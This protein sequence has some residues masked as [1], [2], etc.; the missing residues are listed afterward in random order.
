LIHIAFVG[1]DVANES[2]RMNR[3]EFIGLAGCAALTLPRSARA[4]QAKPVIG[5]LHSGTGRRTPTGSRD[6]ARAWPTRALSK[7]RTSP[8]ISLGGRTSGPPARHEGGQA[9]RRSE[10]KQQSE[11]SQKEGP[12]AYAPLTDELSSEDEAR[13][14]REKQGGR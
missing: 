12:A 10:Q 1:Q 2:I 8:S 5:F 3:R 11:K 13:E 6:F 7:T 4:Q 14:H 9:D